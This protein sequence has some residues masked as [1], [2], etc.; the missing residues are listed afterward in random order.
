MST[1]RQTVL[2]DL[3]A[4]L[5]ARFVPFAGWQMPVQFDGL[6]EEHLA[7][8]Q[9]AG[10][11]DLGHMGRLEV[12]GADAVAFLERQTTRAL[13][14]MTIGQVR[15]GLLTTDNGGVIDDVLFRAAITI[16]GILLSTPATARR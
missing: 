5:G 11:F 6:K 7:V 15:Y 13:A 12:V 14:D 16:T 9:H 8:R 4:E 2:Y 10:V 3:Q 1:D